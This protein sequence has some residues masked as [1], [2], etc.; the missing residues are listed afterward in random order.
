[1]AR[2]KDIAKLANVSPS[3]VSNVIHG[4]KNK[5]S[6]ELYEKVQR[7]LEEEH[8]VT[9]RGAQMLTKQGSRL[10][11][12]IL[13]YSRAEEESI[14]QDSF[15][16]SII[17]AVQS[18]LQK[19][20]YFLLLYA[21]PDVELCTKITLEWNVEGIILLG[22]KREGYY[23]LRSLNS[24]PV[25][26]IDTI[27]FPEDHFYVNVGLEDYQ[28]AL[29]MTRYLLSKGH[30]KIAFLSLMDG[31]D[32]LREDAIDN[33]RYQ[34]YLQAYQ[35]KN[36]AADRSLCRNLSYDGKIRQKQ[37]KEFYQEGFWGCTALFFTADIMALEMMSFCM[38]Q[39]LRVPE[40]I[41]IAGYDGI[42]AAKR[43]RPRLCT[44]CQDSTEKGRRA[45]TE[46]LFLLK[47][48]QDIGTCKKDIRL[49]VFLEEGSSVHALGKSKPSP[50]LKLHF[51]K[52]SE[53][54][55]REKFLEEV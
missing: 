54:R 49:P 25:V 16:S 29:E 53:R 8:Y 27:F 18:A 17:G 9:H 1:M 47:E 52:E 7:I 11:A 40:D 43:A 14:V 20:G 39:G 48:E 6:P 51:Q 13:A 38:D 4:R 41:S 24:V 42:S 37:Y 10:I 36:L 5:L 46:L 12:L 28:G 44:I 45:V 26:T 33:I 35:E 2:I 50:K 30:E 22:A 34:G 31:M 21:N 32:V 19:E 23:Y 55:D 15:V 3:T